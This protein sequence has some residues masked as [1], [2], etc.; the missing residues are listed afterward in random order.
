MASSFATLFN[1]NIG[2]EP[3]FKVDIANWRCILCKLIAKQPVQTVCGHRF[4]EPCLL[5]KLPQDIPVRCP[6]NKK[7]CKM[8]ARGE[9][10]VSNI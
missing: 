8:L 5:E 1:A 4:C 7:E 10:T 6:A 3:V 2:Y 9:E